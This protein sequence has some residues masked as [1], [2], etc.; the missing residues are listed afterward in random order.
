MRRRRCPAGADDGA[1]ARRLSGGVEGREG[2]VDLVDE[3]GDLAKLRE[4]VDRAKGGIEFF[5]EEIWTKGIKQ[6]VDA[7]GRA[8]EAAKKGGEDPIV[9]CASLGT[10]DN[11]CDVLT[12]KTP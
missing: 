6:N 12:P 2:R 1:R 9:V 11:R 3:G 10:F 4:A 7:R 8:I 5:I